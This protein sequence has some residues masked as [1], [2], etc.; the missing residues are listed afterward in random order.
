MIIKN[1]LIYDVKQG[2]KKNDLLIDNGKIVKIGREITNNVD[3]VVD[4]DGFYVVPG[5]IDLHTHGAYGFDTMTATCEELDK[6]SLFYAS[7]GVTAYLPTTITAP[8]VN[9][10]RSLE[11]VGRRIKMGTSGAKILGVNL[12]GPY[13][14]SKFKGAHPEEYIMHPTVGFTQELI[15][16]SQDNIRMIT[17]APELD[18]VNELIEYF[19]HSSIVFAIGHSALNSNGAQQ[20][21]SQDITHVTHLFNAMVGIHH[22]EPGL[23][24]AALDND[25]VTVEIIADGIHINPSIIRMVVKCKSP[26][27]IALV[28]DSTMAA[29]LDDGEYFLGEQK[30]YVKNKVGRLSSGVL[31]GSTLTMIDAVRNMVN[32][33]KIP[34]EHVIKMASCTPSK[35]INLNHKKGSIDIGKDADIVLLDGEL[36]VKMTIV[37]GRVVFK[38]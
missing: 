27:K 1:G 10:V 2:F 20:V 14:N 23:A 37:E 7:K 33:F 25:S 11:N 9:I 31:S 15:K 24:G 3:E 18:G 8:V 34:M 36:N 28:T 16:K 17:L 19:K 26:E 35:I 13:V 22:R 32:K 29:G 12:E 6:M 21:F 5:F 4:A 38:S 30:V